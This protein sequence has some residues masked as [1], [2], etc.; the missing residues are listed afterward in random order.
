[1]APRGRP[2]KRRLT[3]MDAA[4]DAMNQLGFPKDLVR[5]TAKGL[6]KEYGGDDGWAFIEGDAYKLLI[7][8]ILDQQEKREQEELKCDK[9]EIVLKDES[10]QE[11]IAGGNAVAVAAGPSGGFAPTCSEVVDTVAPITEGE[12]EKRHLRTETLS[13]RDGKDRNYSQKRTVNVSSIFALNVGG[14][15][16]VDDIPIYSPPPVVPTP[17]PVNSLPTPRRRKPCYG[18]ISSSDDEADDFV[19]LAPA[20]QL[21]PYV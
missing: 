16:H 15:I 18:W 2:R 21:T 12:G 20:T 14:G 11:C 1:M 6:L 4:I 5:K 8:T 13:K 10:L 3:R 7:E 17:S 9:Q 19:Q